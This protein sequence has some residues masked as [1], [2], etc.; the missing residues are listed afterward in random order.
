VLA[1]AADEFAADGRLRGRALGDDDILSDRFAGPGEAARRNAGEH[2]L[3]HHARQRVA[4]GE[5]RIRRQPDFPLAVS[6]PRARALHTDTA[7]AQRDLA[8]L[9]A[10]AHRA[11]VGVALAPRPDDLIDLGFHHLGQHAEPDADA[12]RQ[13]PVLRGVHQL[14]Q[15][16]LHARRQR[17][18]CA[19]DLLL[20]YGPHGG[21]FVSMDDFATR[22]APNASGRGDRTATYEVLRATGQ[23]RRDDR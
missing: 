1:G 15:R 18:L 8:V 23:P 17:Q 6:G 4:I 13:Q 2:L 12:Q 7:P 21:P 20:L 10:V 3:E 5:V 19:A 11:A 9:V 16:L 14:A 22:H